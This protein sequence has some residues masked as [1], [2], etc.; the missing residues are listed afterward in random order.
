[1][2]LK[3]KKDH[4][5]H[6]VEKRGRRKIFHL[7]TTNFRAHYQYLL[8]EHYANVVSKTDIEDINND[9]LWYTLVRKRRKCKFGYDLVIW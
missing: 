3:P 6:K 2:F 5:I 1:M 7:I 8:P 4:P 9:K